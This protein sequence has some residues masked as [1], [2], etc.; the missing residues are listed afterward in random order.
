MCCEV[1]LEQFIQTLASG[2]LHATYSGK[3]L[4]QLLDAWAREASGNQEFPQMAFAMVER[5]YKIMPPYATLLYALNRFCLYLEG[6]ADLHEVIEQET[7]SKEKIIGNLLKDG[8]IIG[9]FTFSQT[10][11]SCFIQNKK[12]KDFSIIVTESAPNN[13]GVETAKTLERAGISCITVP[14]ADMDWLAQQVDVAIF[15]CEG[16]LPDGSVITKVGQSQ[17]AACCEKRNKPVYIY[18]GRTKLIPGPFYGFKNKVSNRFQQ[19]S[20][21]CRNFDVTLRRCITGIVTEAGIL[22]PDGIANF[23]KYPVSAF[24]AKIIS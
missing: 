10:L 9:T 15:G 17:L 6:K 18:A 24:L 7:V 23:V 5:I 2:T 12:G 19:G 20:I 21:S 1:L 4:M 22:S 16:V 8:T 3:Q 14:D 11:C 13:D